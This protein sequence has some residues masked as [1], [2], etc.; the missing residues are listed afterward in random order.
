VGLELSRASYIWVGYF[1]VADLTITD[2]GRGEATC[3]GIDFK[4]K[5]KYRLHDT[6][7]SS[8]SSPPRPAAT[9][10]SV[11]QS[12]F[13]DRDSVPFKIYSN[14]SIDATVRKRRKK[15]SIEPAVDIFQTPISSKSHG[16]SVSKPFFEFFIGVSDNIVE[17]MKSMNDHGH[18]CKGNLH[19]RRSQVTTRRLELSV[20]CQC[21]LGKLC[22]VL[23]F[24]AFKWQSTSD[25]STNMSV[26]CRAT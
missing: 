2:N 1:H 15:V 16:R 19:F 11:L 3:G 6:G 7:N 12:I 25:I 22:S 14:Q 20:R 17:L 8:L 9:K 23:P 4:S 18:R 5:T 10:H 13:H 26:R 21:S 24:G